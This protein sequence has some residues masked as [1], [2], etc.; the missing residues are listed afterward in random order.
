MRAWI[1]SVFESIQGRSF[2]REFFWTAGEVE[3]GQWRN[4]RGAESAAIM[5]NLTSGGVR[6]GRSCAAGERFNSEFLHPLPMADFALPDML[7]GGQ[8]LLWR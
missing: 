2:Q 3:R 5:A 1:S 4:L 8:A 6:R 7:G